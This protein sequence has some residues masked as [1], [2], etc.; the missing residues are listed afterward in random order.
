M[1]ERL[2][3]L[4]Y[5]VLLLSSCAAERKMTT[6]YHL[7]ASYQDVQRQGFEIMQ[8]RAAQRDE[9][10]RIPSELEKEKIGQGCIR[11]VYKLTYE[12]VYSAAHRVKGALSPL[13]VMEVEQRTNTLIIMD[14]PEVFEGVENILK[15]LD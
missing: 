8:V 1:K 15:E 4:F 9:D 14:K 10:L 6:S 13:G 2:L 11:K 12:D 3:L 7:G 5:I